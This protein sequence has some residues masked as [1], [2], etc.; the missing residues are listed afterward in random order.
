MKKD[1]RI[2]L[3]IGSLD[4]SMFQAGADRLKLSL[5]EF[6]M[7]GA[8]LQYKESLKTF[9]PEII[10]IKA[11]K[12]LPNKMIVK[13]IAERPVEF[14]KLKPVREAKVEMNGGKPFVCLLKGK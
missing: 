6:L 10:T 11:T 5:S 8:H 14:S 2:M 9:D 4:K 3:R 1:E 13:A 12:R 7:A